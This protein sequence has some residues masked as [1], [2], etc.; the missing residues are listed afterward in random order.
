MS[1]SRIDGVISRMYDRG[2][3]PQ[4][5]RVRHDRW[6]VCRAGDV[7]VWSESRRGF[8]CEMGRDL[9]L[10]AGVVRDGWGY[11]FDAAPAAARP[12]AQQGMLCLV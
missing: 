12:V 4:R 8:V 3:L 5:V 7:L 2:D 10:R 9:V 6:P 1:T 11:A